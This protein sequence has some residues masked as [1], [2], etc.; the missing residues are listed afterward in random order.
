MCDFGLTMV[1]RRKCREYRVGKKTYMAPEV[2]AGRKPYD[3]QKSDLWSLGMSLFVLLTGV[4]GGWSRCSPQLLLL[5]PWPHLLLF[6]CIACRCWL[7]HALPN[8]PLAF[9]LQFAPYE[10]P[11]DMDERFQYVHAATGG[12]GRAAMPIVAC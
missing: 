3:A 9:P 4:R 12:G 2:Y 5:D 7:S 10:S 8:P 1:Q 6:G 11:S